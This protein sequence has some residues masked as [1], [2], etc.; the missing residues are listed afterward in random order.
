MPGRAG[1]RDACAGAL[2]FS[3]SGSGYGVF[4][5]YCDA[6]AVAWSCESLCLASPRLL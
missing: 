6:F 3:V 1:K 5:I 2:G 4:Q